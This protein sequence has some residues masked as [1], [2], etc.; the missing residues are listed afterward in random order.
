MFQIM[1]KKLLKYFYAFIF[2]A[3]SLFW[4]HFSRLPPLDTVKV[5]FL[6]V[7]QGDSALI[8]TPQNL[9][10]LVDG[11]PN[12]AVL[13]ELGDI[14]PYLNKTFDLIVLTHPHRDHLTGLTEVLKRYK[15]KKVLLTDI[16][17]QSAIYD[18]FL[19]LL[20]EKEVSVEFA[21]ADRDFLVSDGLYLDILY[22]FSSFLGK[23][24]D[25]NNSSI[26]FRLIFG[27]NEVLFTGDSEE[28]TENKLLMTDFDLEADILKVA[29]HG[30]KDATSSAYL[31]TV[32]PKTAVISCGKDNKFGHPH[33]ETI[34]RLEK[35][36]IDVFRTDVDGRMEIPIKA[37]NIHPRL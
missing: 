26:V 6:N 28:S 5:T 23:N 17:H 9:Q 13:N 8:Q 2:V 7:G 1:P 4:L 21:R 30:S 36:G 14:L 29:H 33:F 16:M 10:I 24:I 15:V 11:G 37:A 3:S 18:E 35:E 25:V 20:R 31:Q 19:R 32:S 27:E 22:P 34:V 12:M